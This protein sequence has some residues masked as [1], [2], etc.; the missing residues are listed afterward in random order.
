MEMVRT[1]VVQGVYG[2]LKIIQHRFHHI[3][4]GR[5]DN[6]ASDKQ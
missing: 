3:R 1:I 5:K 2:A 4:F 6:P